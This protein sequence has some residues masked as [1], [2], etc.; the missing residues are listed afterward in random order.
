M[1]TS[2]S[3]AQHRYPLA[4]SRAIVIDP[5]RNFGRPIL[6][7]SGIDTGLLYHA[8]LA[9]DKDRKRIAVLYEIPVTDVDAVI[10]FEGGGTA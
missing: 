9:E 3:I 5:D 1:N 8:Y 7:A 6:S 10:A 2:N 4:R